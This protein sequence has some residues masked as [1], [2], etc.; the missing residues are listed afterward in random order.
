LTDQSSW[1]VADAIFTSLMKKAPRGEFAPDLAEACDT[2]DA[3]TWTCQL[4]HDVFFHDGRQLRAADVAFTYRSV[5]A[6]DFRSSK[7][8]A[9]KIIRAIETPGEDE[10]VFRLETPYASFPNQLLLGIIPAGTSKDEAKNHPVGTGPFLFE[11]FVPDNRVTIRRFDRY[12][13]EKARMA[14]VI[15]RVIPDATTRAL[16]LLRGSVHLVINSLPPDMLPRLGTS[17]GVKVTILPGSNHGY[18]AFNFKDPVLSKKEVR[19][20]LALA[21]DRKAIVSGLWRDTVEQT[22]TLLPDDHW[23]TAPDLPELKRDLAEAGRLLDTAGFPVPPGGGPRLSLTYKTSTDE[24]TVLQAT[25]I[26]AQ[27]R[28]AGVETVIRSHDFAVFY[29]DVIRGN[30]RVFSMRWQGITDPDHYHDVFHSRSF[31]PRGWN[32]GHFSDPLVDSWIDQARQILARPERQRLYWQIQRRVSEE[33]PYIPLYRAR[34]V[35]VHDSR[36]TGIEAIPPTG[37]FTFLREIGRE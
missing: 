26:A 6:E 1:R 32:R 11:S 33:L 2:T 31:P 17:P 16:E 29:D 14:R 30:F 35:A 21:L 37:D 28:E 5:L 15:Y 9:L 7:K 10:V 8:Q 18:V 3:Q 23:A 36:L 25:A 12:Y 27:W 19:R 20:A 13:G 22:E 34:N 4:R 24:M